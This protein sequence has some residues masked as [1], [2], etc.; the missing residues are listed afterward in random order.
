MKFL[1][2]F[3]YLNTGA[4]LMR[5]APGSDWNLCNTGIPSGN[6][7]GFSAFLKTI[8]SLM[9][10]TPMESF[11]TTPYWVT[12]HQLPAALIG[13]G[14]GGFYA[15]HNTGRLWFTPNNLQEWTDIEP[16]RLK[17]LTELLERTFLH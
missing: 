2:G 14:P 13:K 12:P 3:Q 16:R 4:G 10:H 1:D 17:L 8:Y 15:C 9:A 7:I 11:T 6:P 5:K